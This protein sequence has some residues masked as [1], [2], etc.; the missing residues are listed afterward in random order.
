MSNLAV[1]RA[2]YPRLFRRLGAPVGFFS[3]IG[4]HSLFYARAIAGMM[5]KVTNQTPP[6]H[7]TTDTMCRTRARVNQSISIGMTVHQMCREKL[8]Q[9]KC[10]SWRWASNRAWTIACP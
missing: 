10:R 1:L 2:T 5:T 4:D 3:R 9:I 7:P 8:R 6:I